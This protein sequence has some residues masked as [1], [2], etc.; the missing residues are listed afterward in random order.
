MKQGRGIQWALFLSFALLAAFGGGCGGGGGGSDG[1]D[2]NSGSSVPEKELLNIVIQR[3]PQPRQ[4][5][6]ITH[7]KYNEYFKEG[8]AEE[9][10]KAIIAAG[11]F[12]INGYAIPATE[13]EYMAN[14][15][16]GY[17]VNENPWLSRKEDC[18][19]G[20]K[21]GGMGGG[22]TCFPSYEEATL[23][24]ATGIPA[25]IEF[26]LYDTD[27][28]KYPDLIETHYLESLIVN[29]AT[30]DE[31]KEAYIVYRGDIDPSINKSD[32]DGRAFDGSRFT[33]GEMIPKANFDPAIEE[34][35]IALFWFG[36]DG[37]VMDKA[38]E[39]E[40]IFVDGADHD[41]YQMDG[42]RYVDDMGFSRDH[43]IISNRPGE[44]ANAHRYFGFMDN[45]ED[46]KVSFWLVPTDDFTEETGA[47]IGFT[48]N[49]DNARIFLTRAIVWAQ[50]RLASVVPSDDGSDAAGD[51]VP[52]GV[53]NELDEAI[54]IAMS[55]LASS[56]TN[57]SLLDY[58]VYL[59]YL[60]L[61]GIEGDMGAKYG[62]Y[63]YT[64]FD[65]SINKQ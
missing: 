15:P 24:V 26:K 44:F 37:W 64:G 57:S 19:S 16:D 6:A 18:W 27:G 60:A 17:E 29:K 28:D 52:R 47:T 36:P 43:I 33:S 22:S 42:T 13:E 50:S 20:G 38:L 39:I 56:N 21:A 12:I 25:G 8:N 23:A 4:K 31:E 34:G 2:G 1:S 9:G 14:H 51:W 48:N 65:K 41:F 46:L 40:G 53:Y 45:K 5:I 49:G 59:L 32:K 54:T 61:N 3:E 7:E 35:D 55:A 10:V 62:G 30:Y 63:T 58:Q 11:N